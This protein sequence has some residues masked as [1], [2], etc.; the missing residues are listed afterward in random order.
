MLIIALMLPKLNEFFDR[1]LKPDELLPAELVSG[2]KK[3]GRWLARQ[4]ARYCGLS[5]AAWIGVL[6]LAAKY[7]HLFS[8]VSILANLFAVPLGTFA[9]MANLGALVCGQWLPWFTELFNHAAW[10]FMVAM[11]WVSVEAAKIPGTY[12]Y[13]L[14]P[15]FATIAI[16]YATVVAIF[17]GWFSTRKRIFLG[18]ALLF[19]IGGVY[20]WQWLSSRDETDLTVLPLD[21]SHAI[22]VDAN[23]RANDWLIN[24]GNKNAVDFTLKDFLHAQGVNTLP[25]LVF[26]EG[27]TKNAGG[28]Q[29]LDE[30][31]HVVELWTSDVKFRSSAYR[32][33]ITSF[34]KPPRHKVLNCGDTVGC[35]QILFPNAT[36]NFSKADDSPLVLRGNFR[37][38]KILLLSDLSRAGQSDLLAT[39]NDLRA[40]IVVAG[41]PTEGEPLCDAL[42]DAIRPRVIVIA[43]SEFPATRRASR[44]LRERLEQKKNSRD[45]HAHRRR[46]EN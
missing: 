20:F 2:W 17:S 8:P 43:D 18:A 15:S 33:A 34:E 5:F 10:F 28:A 35:W 30:L 41:L 29:T 11:T 7:F 37:G 1:L 26:T 38:T 40:D 12:F 22:Y 46:G 24:C 14:E 21:G 44:A 39:T 42:I 36:D 4:F 9:L 23:G 16:Y 45:L 25:R 32:D 13:V 31:F 3:S 27:D 19:F 6:P